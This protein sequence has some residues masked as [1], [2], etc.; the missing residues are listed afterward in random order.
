VLVAFGPGWPRRRLPAREVVAATPVQSP[1][2][3]GYGIRLTPQGWMWNIAGPHGVQLLLADGR[4][5]RVGT[6]DPQGLCA[7]LHAASATGA[8]A[9]PATASGR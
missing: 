9:V 1:W 3:W 2:W 4:R 5:L 6:D 7:A 8:G